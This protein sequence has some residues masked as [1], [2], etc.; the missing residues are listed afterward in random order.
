MKRKRFQTWLFCFFLLPVRPFS[1]CHRVVWRVTCLFLAKIYTKLSVESGEERGNIFWKYNA[2]HKRKTNSSKNSTWLHADFLSRSQSY[3]HTY[4]FWKLNKMGNRRCII[5]KKVGT[6]GIFSFP[7]AN[8]KKIREEWLKVC[9][10]PASTDTKNIFVCFRHF[11]LK[12]LE[13]LSNWFKP[14]PG[15]L[16]IFF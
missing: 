11:H 13:E 9:D 16:N 12:D 5:C 15:K 6:K 1:L 10:L 7:P 3:N 2:F 14:F 4:L 8:R